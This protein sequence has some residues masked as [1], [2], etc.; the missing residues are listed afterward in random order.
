MYVKWSLYKKTQ[1]KLNPH[2]DF[3]LHLKLS[4]I[5]QLL[6]YGHVLH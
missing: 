3:Y 2:K 6:F 1:V 5:I 4:K